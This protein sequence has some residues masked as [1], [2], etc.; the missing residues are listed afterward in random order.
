MRI[1]IFT[2]CLFFSS[3]GHAGNKLQSDFD[4]LGPTMKTMEVP[5]GRTVVYL[6]EGKADWRPVVFVGGSGTSGRVFAMLE[7]LR[8]TRQNLKLRFIG[9]ERNG[10]GATAFDDSLGYED[11]AE[12]VE[13]ILAHLGVDE[14]S[15]FAISGGG[16]YAAVIA[17]RN[18]ERLISVH[19]ASALTYE[20]PSALQCVAPAEALTFYT[21]DPVAW[22]GFPPESPVHR[23]PGFQDAAFDDAARTFNMGGQAGDPAALH[24]EF[25]LYCQNQSLPD[26]AAVS[27]PV[28]LYYGDADPLTPIDPHAGRW[29][30][31]FVNA[32]FKSRF[33]PGEGHDAQYRHLDQILVD[34]AGMG[35]KLVVCKKG[36]KN[37]KLVKESKAGKILEKG[38]ILGICAWRD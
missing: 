37:P 2:L 16:P 31:A 19:L 15:L 23:I 32:E 24:H 17:S 30:I 11:Y 18:A 38:G 33:Y 7:F 9:V 34:I 14:F 13:A 28:Y 1:T 6:D 22:F 36:D 21:Q 26:L 12:D 25:Q 5:S 8:E 29:L 10:F 27:A 20:D 3:F 35:D 4:Y